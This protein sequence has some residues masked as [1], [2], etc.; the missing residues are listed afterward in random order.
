MCYE[1]LHFHQI[2]FERY[3]WDL[4]AVT[5]FVSAGKFFADFV[6]LPWRAGAQVCRR[7]E[8]SA[9]YCLPGDPVPLMIYPPEFTVTGTA[10]EAGTVVALF[11]IFP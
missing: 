3:G 6:T 5:P 10:L 9:G 7:Y 4:G 1:R 2:N 8:C 11:A